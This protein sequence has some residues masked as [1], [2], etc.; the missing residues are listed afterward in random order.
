MGGR[1]QSVQTAWPCLGSTVEKPWLG[2]GGRFQAQNLMD[3]GQNVGDKQAKA[4]LSTE[5]LSNHT[6]TMVPMRTIIVLVTTV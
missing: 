5:P 6:L 2:L 4:E 3:L 1:T